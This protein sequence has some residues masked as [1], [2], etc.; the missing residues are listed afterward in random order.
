M[1]GDG[2]LVAP[3]MLDGEA[4]AAGIMKADGAILGLFQETGLQDPQGVVHL[5]NKWR[6]HGYHAFPG[7]DAQAASAAAVRGMLLI[8]L[9]ADV[10]S[11]EEVRDIV[12]IVPGKAMAL[13]VVTAGGTLTVINVHGPGSSGDSWASKA[14]L[15]A[16]V[17][18]Y[19]AAKSAGGTRAVLLGGDFNVWLESPRHPTTRRFQ[20]LWEPCGF[21]RAGAAA[22]EDRRP[23]RAGHRLDSFLLNSPLVPWAV[24]ERPHVAPGRS[25]ASLG[26]D[27]CP[28]VL[29]IPLAVA[30]KE[31]VT[32][33]A[34]SH[35]QG[36][37]HA[38]R[39]DS[40]GVREAAAAVLQ[41]ACED[42]MLRA[43]LLSDQDTATMGTSE[44]QAV[45]DLIYAF[46]DDVS[47]VTG[48][49]MPSGMDPQYPYGQAETEASLS[50]V[51]SD[52]QALAW[53]AHELWQRDAA[54]AG[55]HSLEGAALLR[56]LRHVDPDLS[57]AR[58]EA[59]R[60]ALDRQVH[61]LETLV[62]ELRDVLRSSMRRSIKD[63]WRGRVPDLQLR[64]TAIRGA[65]NVVNYAL[66]GLWSV[67]VRESEKVLMEAWDVIG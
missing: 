8:A 35:A 59:L 40:P 64:W 14:S 34:Y 54:T 11:A 37:L 2:I 22:E 56:H 63:Y 20:A 6:H 58:V 62:E 48:V 39:P 18:M 23:T 66:S 19:A 46:R 33:M 17:A 53:R 60:A 28:V 52:Q 25:P 41:K 3:G 50:Q 4:V 67:R 12:G 26:C 24:R 30:G 47:R 32:R 55:L 57:P 65:I 7:L 16:D 29:D 9:R 42:R 15:W 1:R 43:W 44:V 31:G 61:Q 10:F 13:D 51:L 38:I 45:F 21:H 36:R 49:R 5:E 27:H